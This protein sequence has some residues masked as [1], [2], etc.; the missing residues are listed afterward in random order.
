[1]SCMHDQRCVFCV[2]LCMCMSQA[3]WLIKHRQ[4]RPAVALVVVHRCASHLI[5]TPVCCTLSPQL[6]DAVCVY[7]RV[8]VLCA[9]M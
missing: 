3:D 6:V 8:C 7:V 1:M 2:W 4:R 5:Y 9:C